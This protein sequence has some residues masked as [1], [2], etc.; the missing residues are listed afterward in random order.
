ML[1]SI[2]V[3]LPRAL[4]RKMLLWTRL[5]QKV[6]LRLSPVLSHLRVCSDSDEKPIRK[7]KEFN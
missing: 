5:L 6:F 7:Q 3:K 2:W 4:D 1:L